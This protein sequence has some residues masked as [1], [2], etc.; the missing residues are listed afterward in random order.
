MWNSKESSIIIKC[1]KVFAAANDISRLS[2]PLQSR[3]RKLFLPKYSEQQFIEVA[4]KVLPKISENLACYIGATV[5]NN[6]GD[7][8]DVISTGRLLKRDDGPDEAAAI[9]NTL[10]KYGVDVKAEG[11]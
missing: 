2:K 3:F 6:N 10:M 9:L 4:V 11:K 8:R 7:I 1:A 5:F